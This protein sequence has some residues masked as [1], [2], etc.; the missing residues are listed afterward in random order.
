MTFVVISLARPTHPALSPSAQPSAPARPANSHSLLAVLAEIAGRRCSG[1]DADRRTKGR[2]RKFGK[3]PADEES[4]RRSLL[5]R[6]NYQVIASRA[7]T[8]DARILTKAVTRAGP[9]QRQ[10]A[11]LL[12]VRQ[13]EPVGVSW[14]KPPTGPP[15]VRSLPPR[16]PCSSKGRGAYH[17]AAKPALMY[18]DKIL[19]TDASHRA[20]GR[21]GAPHADARTGSALNPGVSGPPANTVSWATAP[22]RLCPETDASFLVK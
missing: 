15:K 2:R 22:H 4:N 12:A 16:P 6:A 8:H 20:A 18:G 13:C 1:Q 19:I 21:R 5:A 17:G 11:A 9:R 3:T 14:V 10:N 7:L